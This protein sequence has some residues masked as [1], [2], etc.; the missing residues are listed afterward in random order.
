[1]ADAHGSGPCGVKP[2]GVQITSPAL[3][4]QAIQRR[5]GD[6]R[7]Y[8]PKKALDGSGLGLTKRMKSP[9]R[10]AKDSSNASM[11]VVGLSGAA[12]RRA[13]RPAI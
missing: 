6:N 7:G 3:L 9:V 4:Q 2:V 5:A 1:M 12:A 11:G 10:S 13:A 8:S